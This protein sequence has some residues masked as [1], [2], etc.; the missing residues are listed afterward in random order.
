MNVDL[1]SENGLAQSLGW[2][3][4]SITEPHEMKLNWPII[5]KYSQL[6]LNQSNSIRYEMR[7]FLY[8]NMHCT[9]SHSCR[10]DIQCVQSGDWIN[11]LVRIEYDLIEKRQFG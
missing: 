11:L 7:F 3:R 9:P 4:I 6:E 5:R 8:L 2:K 1:I 10:P